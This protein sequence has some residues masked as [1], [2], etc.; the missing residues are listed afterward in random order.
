[1]HWLYPANTKFYDVFGAFREAETYWPL[2]SKVSVGDTVFIYL[3][4]PHKQVAFDY[5]ILEVGLEESD[6]IEFVRPF[7]KGQN[8]DKKF[9][10]LFVKL[11]V[12]SA[13]PLRRDSPLAYEYLKKHGLSGMLMG[14]RKLEN[15]PTLLTYIEGETS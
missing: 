11:Q 6:V 4:G 5:D 2:N 13:I 15:N 8:H 3:A 10:K 7:F 9:Q 1:M 12:S 14:P